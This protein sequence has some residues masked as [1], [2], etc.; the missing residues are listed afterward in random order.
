MVTGK[1]VTVSTS[2]TPIHTA[3]APN[4]ELMVRN[5]NAGTVYLGGS[6][7]DTT[8]GFPLRTGEPLSMHLLPND[9]LY[10]IVASGTLDVEVL[11]LS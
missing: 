7:V 11:V 9:T 4:A 10:G 1:K 2:A 5:S 8:S 6:A 3:G